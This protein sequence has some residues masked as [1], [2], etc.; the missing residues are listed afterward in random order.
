MS[1]LRSAGNELLED[2]ISVNSAPR[3]TIVFVVVHSKI[4]LFVLGIILISEVVKHSNVVN[5][6]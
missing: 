1:R 6:V 2:R 3:T 5:H 4:I